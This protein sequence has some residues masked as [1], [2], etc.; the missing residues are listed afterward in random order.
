MGIDRT[1]KLDVT[2]RLDRTQARKLLSEILN[3]KGMDN[4]FSS[5]HC[6]E[7][8]EK[9]NMTMCDVFNVLHAGHIYHDAEWIDVNW[10]YRVETKKMLVVIAFKNP[11]TI[12][13]I[14]AW[15]K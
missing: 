2:S 15:R 14:T 6:K 7:E 11:D 10:R 13:C 1:S 9:D 4:V 12:W 5:R 3:K 8:L